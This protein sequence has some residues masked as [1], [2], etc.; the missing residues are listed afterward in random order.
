MFGIKGRDTLNKPQSDFARIGE[1]IRTRWLK[2][3]P[4]LLV[5]VLIFVLFFVG[6]V[7]HRFVYT[8][9]LTGDEKT[10]YVNQKKSEITFDKKR[11]D[12]VKERILERK[13]L[14]ERERESFND[15]FYH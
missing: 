10:N 7:W 8:K 1:Y 13:E 15:V 4:I 14:Y 9:E 11:F 3:F 2:I 12:A 5:L 6:Y